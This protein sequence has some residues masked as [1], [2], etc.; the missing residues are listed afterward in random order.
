MF[1]LRLHCPLDTVETVSDALME[2]GALSVST[3][4]ADAG[5]DAEQALFGEPGM[6]APAGG[7]QTNLLLALFGT[8]R[9]ARDTASLLAAQDFAADVQLLDIE[10]VPDQDWVR[11]SQ[12]QFEPIPVTPDFWIVPSWH[13]TPQ[14]A[15]TIIRLDPGVA[16]GTGT[17]PTT[18]MCLRWIAGNADCVAHKRV[19]DYG[20]G[21]G[22]LAIAAALHHA[23]HVH[24]V[25]IDTAAVQAT[26][27]NAEHN[28]VT[29]HAR[30]ATADSN[31][32]TDSS[33]DSNAG[34]SAYDTVLANILAT[35]LKLLAPLLCRQLKPGGNLILSG[36]LERQAQELQHAY[37][38]YLSLSVIDTTDGWILMHGQ[39]SA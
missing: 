9:Q 37:Q 18:S 24:A 16:F 15:R 33:T 38:P 8:E 21:S 14:A 11:I 26:R 7:W 20:C 27:Q 35:P 31:T 2:Y 39:K 6:P 36:I 28:G 17:H 30:T 22:I 5:T 4:D 10:A 13:D 34:S 29:V 19:M 3:C 32:D 12:S 25:D 1:Q 23:A